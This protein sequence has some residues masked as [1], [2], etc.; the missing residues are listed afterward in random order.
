MFRYFFLTD[1]T[2]DSPSSGGVSAK[3]TVLPTPLKRT[4][5]QR[6]KEGQS[7][8]SMNK[9]TQDGGSHNVSVRISV[10]HSLFPLAWVDLPSFRSF[11]VTE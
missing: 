9:T 4:V 3:V 6:D 8:G 7:G 5:S 11:F 2:S 10:E 1:E